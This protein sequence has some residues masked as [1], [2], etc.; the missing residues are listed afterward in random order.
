MGQEVSATSIQFARAGPWSRTGAAGKA[1][2]R[3]VGAAAAVSDPLPWDE[4]QRVIAPETAIKMRQMMEGVVLHGTGRKAILH[5][6]TSGGKTGSAQIYDFKT[7]TYT[8]SYNASFVGFAPVSN[9]QIVIAVTL[10]GTTGSVNGF[11]GA[12]A[13]PVF[14][15]VA[16][17]ALR[18]LDV[19]K[20]LPE[21][22][23]RASAAPAGD[24][25]DD[26]AE[27]NDVAIAGLGAPPELFSE[28]AANASVKL[29][30]SSPSSAVRTAPAPALQKVSAPARPPVFSSSA[31]SSVTPP[32]VQ[33]AASASANVVSLDRRPFLD[34][35]A[36][37]DRAVDKHVVENRVAD[38]HTRGSRVPD[39]RRVLTLNTV[40]EESAASGLPVEVFGDGLARNRSPPGRQRA[41]AGRP[42]PRAVRQIGDRNR[43]DDPGSG[44]ARREAPR[45]HC[46]CVGFVDGRGIRVRFAAREEG[47]RVFCISR[48]ARRWPQ[49]C[50][51]CRR[52]GSVCH[53]ERVAVSR[54][55]CS[56]VG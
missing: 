37:D 15:D 43:R 6:Y 22:S 35:R 5:G 7:H 53:C 24:K 48:I 38:N 1:P 2:H 33:G 36:G 46:S 42:G 21:T 31:V 18:M 56:A 30:P 25:A 23:V 41:P 9:P 17:S 26:K 32:P 51:G 20:D 29:S 52:T 39:F 4:P 27:V 28:P 44:A 19:P 34:G 50:N 47:F 11:G 14:H 45:E 13:A 55:L 12:T 40:L 8:H 3:V 10:I 54:R 16:M 49:I